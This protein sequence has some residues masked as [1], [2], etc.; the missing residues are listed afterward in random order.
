MTFSREIRE[1]AMNTRT[2]VISLFAV[3][4][5]SAVVVATPGFNTILNVIL[6]KG[7]NVGTLSEGVRIDGS[8]EGEDNAH[9][10]NHWQVMLTT[11]GDSDFYVQDAIVGPGGFSGWHSHPGLLLVTVKSG[12]I[13]W[14][15]AN[16]VKHVRNT[17]DSFTESDENHQL[18]NS[19]SENTEL[20]IAYIIKRGAPRRI[21]LPQAPGCAAAAGIPQ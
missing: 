15:D 17:G 7:T 5:T 20:L 3:L 21:D 1:K 4:G 14:Y 6:A 2:I 18:V 19:G 10:G 16:C 13:D 12:T 11:S 8:V 9:H